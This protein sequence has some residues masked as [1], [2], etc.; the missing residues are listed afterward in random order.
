M[1][2]KTT[3]LHRKATKCHIQMLICAESRGEL[4]SEKEA[5]KHGLKV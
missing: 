1:G 2:L 5:E 4:L 3:K